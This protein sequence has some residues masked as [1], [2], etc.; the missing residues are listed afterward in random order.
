MITWSTGN[1]NN[2]VHN[3]SAALSCKLNDV[4]YVYN[5]DQA[6]Y[7]LQRRGI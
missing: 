5:L 7:T 2:I 6:D 4:Q 1:V 3:I